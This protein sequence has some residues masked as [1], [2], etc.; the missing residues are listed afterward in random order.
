M[1]A[2]QLVRRGITDPLVLQAMRVLPR[3]LFVPDGMRESA[4]DDS[5]LGIWE[6]QTIS[7]PYIVAIMT[8][9][10]RLVPG[11]TVLEI[12]T[13]SGYQ[14]AVLAE[15]VD[16]VDTVEI[17]PGLVDRAQH[18]WAHCGCAERIRVRVGDGH[19]GWPEHGPYDAIVVTCA[20]RS[21][22]HGLTDQLAPLG[23]LVIPT[24]ATSGDQDLQLI[25]KD[26]HGSVSVKTLMPVR[27]VRMTGSESPARPKS[28]PE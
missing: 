24:G 27:F 10:L 14:T 28:D 2:E 26:A 25:E 11:R 21:I 5:A 16:L 7:Q 9:A 8:Q 12:G 4:Y 3:H 1:V 18:A 23:K 22:P 6:G 19:I 13:G 15:I 20:P 17:L